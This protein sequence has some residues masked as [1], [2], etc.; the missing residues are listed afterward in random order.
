MKYRHKTEVFDAHR[1]FENGGHPEDECETR[2]CEG[3]VVMRP[4]PALE[5]CLV[6]GGRARA[7]G[8]I[9]RRGGGQT[10]CPGDY[11]VTI[12][13]N[14]YLAFNRKIFEQIYEEARPEDYEED[15]GHERG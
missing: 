13:T 3:K 11:V 9:K 1:W 6:C 2:E 4:P 8:W 14:E 12:G 5:K 7:H 10:V 15:H